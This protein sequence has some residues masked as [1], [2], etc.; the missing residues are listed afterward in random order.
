MD[1]RSFIDIFKKQ[2]YALPDGR[3]LNFGIDICNKLYPDYVNFSSFH[4]WGDPKV[5]ID[6]IKVCEL[7]KSS[8]PINGEVEKMMVKVDEIAPHMDNFGDEVSSYSLN[9]CVAVYHTL[10]YINTQEAEDIFWVGS[11]MIDTIDFKVQENKKLSDEEIDKHPLMVET[12]NYLLEQ[13]R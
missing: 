11:T 4:K 2:V 9:A 10:K 5:L 3:L 13:T 7:A 1:Y 8:L 6:A 12:Q